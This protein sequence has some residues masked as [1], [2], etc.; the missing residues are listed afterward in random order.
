MQMKEITNKMIV[1][2]IHRFLLFLSVEVFYRAEILKILNIN[3]LVILLD[4]FSEID[5]DAIKTFVDVI[6]APLNNWS[7]DFIKFKIAAYPNRVFYGKI[8]PGKV[9]TINLDFYNLYSKVNRNQMEEKAI[10]FTHRLIETR[11]KHFTSKSPE[12]FFDTKKDNINEYYKLLF[13]VSMNVPRII[14]YI[15]SYSSQ[16]SINS[17]RPINKT[18]IEFASQRY[19]E[20]NLYPFFENTTY[21]TLTIDE[22]IPIL[23]LKILLEQ[24][25]SKLAEI[26]KRIQKGDLGGEAYNPNQPYASHFFFE[27][28]LEKYIQT[29]ELN[30]FITKYDDMISKKVKKASIYC[31]NYGLAKKF[32]LPWGRPED[33]KYARKYFIETP[34]DFN[35]LIT[36]FLLK[37]KKIHCTNPECNQQFTFND[38]PNLEFTHFKC[39]HCH[40]IVITE[41]L[42]SKD[43]EEELKIDENLLLPQSDL[44]IIFALAKED[45]PVYAR[46]IAGEIDYSPQF[47]GH[48]CRK[49]IE[50]SGLIIRSMARAPYKYQ[51]TKK[52]F[53][54]YIHNDAVAVQSD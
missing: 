27:P 40:S 42:M 1:C 14:G 13:Q 12:F 26:K 44:K 50:E 54:N 18:D 25:V 32:N 15:L 51:L 17:D 9:D 22:K 39:P 45:A 29:L 48:R 53:D 5:D 47:I 24:I 8:D 31:I 11:I 35:S 28:K 7:E 38:M 37:S 10:D 19:Y 20:E 34:F 36:E 41:D 3:H 33:I 30:F 16:N 2:N 49:M 23:Q 4:D 43:V 52:A 21:S 46:E 6:L